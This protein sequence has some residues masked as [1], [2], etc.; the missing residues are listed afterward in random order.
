MAK[1]AMIKLSGEEG[2]WQVD[3]EQ[4]TVSRLELP[5]GATETMLSGTRDGATGV[6]VAIAMDTEAAHDGEQA[7]SGQL[8]GEQAFSG[9]LFGKNA[10]SGQL[11]GKNAF[12]GQLFGEPRNR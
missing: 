11:F 6:D 8:F 5:E 3:F 2:F 10:F 12:S 9:Q 4:G 7:F 1:F